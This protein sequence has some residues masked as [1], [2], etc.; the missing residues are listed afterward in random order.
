MEEFN[1]VNGGTSSTDSSDSSSPSTSEAGSQEASPSQSQDASTPFHE[2]PRFQE[3]IATKN[4][5]AQELAQYKG[6]SNA[7]LHK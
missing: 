2:H 1:D 6:D 3:L 7:W 5:Q 4:Q